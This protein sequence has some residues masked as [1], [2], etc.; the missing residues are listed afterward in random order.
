MKICSRVVLN[1]NYFQSLK[2]GHLE[3]VRARGFSVSVG[4]SAFYE[5]WAA[6][7]REGKIGI[8]VGPARALSRIVDPEYPIAP[9][10]GDFFW[11]FRVARRRRERDRVTNRFR[12]WA[13]Y[14]WHLAAT[15]N[16]NEK[17]LERVGLEADAY[18]RQRGQ[19]WQTF[20]KPWKVKIEPDCPPERRSI[21]E[22]LN[23]K[24]ELDLKAFKSLDPRKRQARFV[25]RV[26][27]GL[28]AR[29]LRAA[30][31]RSRFHAFFNVSGWHMWNTACGATT[32]TENDSEDVANLM[33]LAE[34]AFLLTRDNKLIHALDESGSYQ[35]PWVRT[36][37]D[38]LA[39]ALPPGRPWGRNARRARESLTRTRTS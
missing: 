24:A 9:N 11:R 27:E 39:S 36:L 4:M 25:A 22:E 5:T 21:L 10:A 34:P 15:G 38:F 18:L 32:A 14:N 30:L 8:I 31:V 19:S 16:V 37:P 3:P 26:D 17:E 1:T 23:A 7:A 29:G 2:E 12:A 20:A 13:V 6:A 28:V 35:A 33:H